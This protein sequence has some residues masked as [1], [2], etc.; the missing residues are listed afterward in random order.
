MINDNWGKMLLLNRMDELDHIDPFY[1]FALDELL[2]HNAGKGGPPICHIWRHP[3]ALIMGHRDSKLPEAKQAQHWLESLGFATIVRNS[4]GAAVPLDA[5]VV[6]ISLIFPK[7][8]TVNY[9]FHDDFELMYELI[10]TALIGTERIVEKGEIVGAYCPGDF[11]LSIDGYKFCGIAQ[12]R[13]T[14]ASIIQAFVV[15]GGSGRSRAELVSSFYDVASSGRKDLD[16]PIVVGNSTASLEELAGLGPQAA[17]RF[18]NAVQEV[19]RSRQ[20]AE[21]VKASSMSLR[22]PEPSEIDEM[23]AT[24]RTRYSIL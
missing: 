4:G 20:S 10:S 1:P 7:D 15:A 24:L 23:I 12:R 3:Q 13:K 14:H 6:N 17:H 22:M 18:A 8:I 2:C 9:H 16:H 5:G 19:I 11:D 21:G